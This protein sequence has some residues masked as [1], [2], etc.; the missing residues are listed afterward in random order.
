M[1]TV[2]C[3]YVLKNPGD[4]FEEDLKQ[5]KFLIDQ[6]RQ[7]EKYILPLPCSV[8]FTYYNLL[9]KFPVPHQ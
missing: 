3:C 5:L 9:R 8:Y 2:N 4:R 6:N 7:H 1:P